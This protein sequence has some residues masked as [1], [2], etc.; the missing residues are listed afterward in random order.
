MSEKPSRADRLTILQSA[1]CLEY[2]KDF[3]GTRAAERA[4][5][6]GKDNS[7]AATSSRLLRTDKVK[8]RVEA[9]VKEKCMGVDE[10]LARL[11][12]QARAEQMLYLGGDG[13]VDLEGLIAGG[14]AHLV[15][16]TKWDKDGNLIIEFADTQAALDK[17]LRAGGAYK[18]NLDLTSDGEQIK[19]VVGG[20]DLEKDI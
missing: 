19:F 14:K 16:G 7:L 15:K 13:A 9:L 4:G 6:T 12:E 2:V 20:V 10:A 1:F 11:A 3:N 17:I 8:A 5:Y 18:D